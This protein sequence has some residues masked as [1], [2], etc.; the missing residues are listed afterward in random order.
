MGV[1]KKEQET[2]LNIR[3]QYPYN[4]EFEYETML[5]RIDLAEEQET[6]I[7]T[8]KGFIIS[9]PSSIKKDLRD[10]DGIFSSRYGNATSDADSFVGDYRCNCGMLRGTINHG[11]KC[12][13]CG[14][15]VKYVGDDMSIFGWIIIKEPYCCIHPNLYRTL[16]AFIGGVRLNNI[17]E[18]S[19]QMDKNG[20]EVIKKYKKDEIFG[21]IGI[22]DFRERFDEVMDYYLSKY[23]AKQMYYDDIMK[24]KDLVFTRFIPVFTTLLRPTNFDNASLKYEKTNE[25]YNMI[26][27]LVKDINKDKLRIDRKKKNKLQLLYD[28]QFQWNI[29]YTELKDIMSGKKGD[30]RAAIGGRCCFTGRSVIVQG[31]DLMPDQIILSYHT[32][33]ELLQQVII[34]ILQRTYNFY[35]A[36]AYK[37]WYKAQLGYS[38]IVYSIIDKLIKDSDGGLPILINRNPTIAYGGLLFVRCIGIGEQEDYTMHISLQVLPLLAADFDGDTLNIMYLLNQDFI[39][40]AEEVISPRNMFISRDDGRFNNLMNHKR[41]VIINANTMKSLSEYTEEEVNQIRMLQSMS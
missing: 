39:N 4:E 5:E 19:V 28:V 27:H 36:D 40:I 23:P 29:I 10:Q 8:G 9:P 37:Y 7:K 15:M 1:G 22:M 38:D 41:D 30:I 18:P 12:D 35:Y 13:A 11:I 26:N 25:N 2:N 34:N 16:E 3:L 24:N 6:D 20:N 31:V 17:I 14:T 21:G 32:L 33:C